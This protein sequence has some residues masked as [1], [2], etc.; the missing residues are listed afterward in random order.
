MKLD[1]IVYTSSTGHTEQYAKMLGQQLD[2]PVYT[3]EEALSQLEGGSRILYLG[4]I[5]A[6]HVSGYVKAKKRFA[7]CSVCG[8][9]LC[10]TGTLIN[11]VR[12]ASSIPESVPLFTLQGGI[13]RSRLT[14]INQLLIAMLSKGL[15]AQKQRSDQ[16][17]RMLQ[18]LRR[19]ASYVQLE[20][21][22]D[23]ID[24]VQKQP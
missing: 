6:S 7:I 20:N 19:D 15:A 18:L 17:E 8:V 24:W 12:K 21:L 4:W 10:D 16:E 9:G 2:L 13:D 11:Q 23:V 3:L 22:T 14:G 5:K 1:A